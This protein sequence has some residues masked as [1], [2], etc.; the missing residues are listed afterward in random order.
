MPKRNIEL[1]KKVRDEVRKDQK[2]KV[3]RFEMTDWFRVPVLRRR[4]GQTFLLTAGD[5][6]HYC[7]S[8]A[9]IAGWSS[10]LHGDKLEVSMPSLVAMDRW[11]DSVAT[12]KGI[13]ARNGVRICSMQDRGQ[14]LLGLTGDEADWVFTRPNREALWVLNKLIAGWSLER[15]RAVAPERR[16]TIRRRLTHA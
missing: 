8:T 12:L 2:R 9:C 11:G 6:P 5:I 1:L 3:K 13:V 10:L 16:R 4:A 14:Y 15:M 7:G